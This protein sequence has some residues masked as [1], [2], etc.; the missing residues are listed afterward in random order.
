MYLTAAIDDDAGRANARLDHYLE[1]YYGQAAAAIRARQICY[2]G[3]AEGFAALMQGYAAAG[4]SH[5]VLRFAGD[6]ER[7]LG[8]LG[9]LRAKL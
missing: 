7:H 4:A 2:A 9:S 1:Q 3:P 8:L 6:H 5:L